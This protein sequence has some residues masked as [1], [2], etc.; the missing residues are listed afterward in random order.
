M[1]AETAGLGVDTLQDYIDIA[2][3]EGFL[4]LAADCG[5]TDPIS[6]ETIRGIAETIRDHFGL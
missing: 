2:T 4:D 5:F 3:E 6:A 1:E